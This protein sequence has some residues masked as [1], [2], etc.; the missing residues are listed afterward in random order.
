MEGAQARAVKFH[1]QFLKPMPIDDLEAAYQHRLEAEAQKWGD[2]LQVEASGRW[3]SWLDHPLIAENYRRRG[4]LDGL[5]W[6]EWVRRKLGGAA[7]RS[8]DLGCGAG[9]KSFGLH[10]A[11]ASNYLEGY[12]ISDARVAHAE[13]TRLASGILGHFQVADVNRL[14]L[15]AD[16][17]DLILSNHSFHHFVDLEHVMKQVSRAL[18]PGG[19][20]VLEEYVGPTQFQ[21]TEE[22]MSLVGTRLSLIPDRLRV[23]SASGTTKLAEGRPTVE[24]VVAESPF[25]SIR[26][27]EIS[28]LFHQFFEV[29]AVRLLGGTLQQLLYNGIIHHFL[30]ED[31]EAM[32]QIRGIVALENELIDRGSI[33]SDFMLLIGR[34]KSVN[35][36]SQIS[37]PIRTEAMT[38]SLPTPKQDSMLGHVFDAYQNLMQITRCIREVARQKSILQP[39]VLEL[40]RYDTRLKNYLP[41]GNILRMPTHENDQPILTRPVVLPYADRSFDCCLVTDAYE[42]L[43]SEMRASLLSE[44][45]RVT[46]GLVLMGCPQ[47]NEIVTRFDQVVFDFIWG[48]YGE[49]FEPLEQHHDFGLDSIEDIETSLK[50]QGAGQVVCLPN[51]YVY[52]WIHMILIYFDLQ[53]QHPHTD[54]FESLNRIY[55]AF[56]S[57][58]DYREPCYRYLMLVATDPSINTSVF[59]ESLKGPAETPAQVAEIEGILLHAFRS[60]DSRASDRLRA[61][62]R[63]M[64]IAQKEISRLKAENE[65]LTTQVL[66]FESRK[67]E[68]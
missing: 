44:M 30:I 49:H 9:D 23:S 25:E 48:K 32:A 52:R 5:R 65:T 28:P 36:P 55:N 68:A 59:T 15:R 67:L 42:H 11:G 16:S 43:P 20:F 46:N 66:K 22:Q 24:Q 41:E 6:E 54:L 33:P 45:I 3:G 19:F 38:S 64:G 53:H 35:G 10:K 21:W 39:R 14:K 40:S 27:S 12:D 8:L 37:A 58:Y 60:I 63:E 29:V 34:R 4:L 31:E 1:L 26:S 61:Y 51:N 56:L 2:H 62:D 17:Y 47:N 50:K 7:N 57:P 18:T 13:K